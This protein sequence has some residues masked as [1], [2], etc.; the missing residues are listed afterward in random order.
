MCRSANHLLTVY[1][2]PISTCANYSCNDLYIDKFV[3]YIY[4]IYIN[5]TAQ[6]ISYYINY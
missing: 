6:L 5:Y 1:K 4:S 2:L 3:I